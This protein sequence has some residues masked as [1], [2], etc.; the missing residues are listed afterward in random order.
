MISKYEYGEHDSFWLIDSVHRELRK[1]SKKFKD[2]FIDYRIN[3]A[4]D[5]SVF[6]TKK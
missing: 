1:D 5:D 2:K 4:I 3:E 6:E